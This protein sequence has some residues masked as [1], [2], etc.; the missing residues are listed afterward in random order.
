MR[1]FITAK[2]PA[3]H[4]VPLQVKWLAL[5]TLFQYYLFTKYK[6]LKGLEKMNEISGCFAKI[7]PKYVAD[8]FLTFDIVELGA[9]F[10]IR[11]TGYRPPELTPPRWQP[12]VSLLNPKPGSQVECKAVE[13]DNRNQNANNQPNEN[14]EGYDEV[15]MADANEPMEEE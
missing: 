11:F 1:N 6:N 12:G 5:T 3:E 14:N 8:F 4:P 9:E 10:N 13:A 2:R 15:D 7:H